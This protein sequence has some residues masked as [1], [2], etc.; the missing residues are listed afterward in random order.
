[1]SVNFVQKSVML[2]QIYTEK[3]VL[4][5]EFLSDAKFYKIVESVV[6]LFCA[7]R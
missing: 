6:S 3:V 1:M 5:L 4:L 7:V 2:K